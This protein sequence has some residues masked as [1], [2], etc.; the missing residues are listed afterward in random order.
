MA[1]NDFVKT[2]LT[3][4]KNVPQAEILRRISKASEKAPAVTKKFSVPPENAIQVPRLSLYDF[5][6]L[7]GMSYSRSPPSS[8]PFP[9][10]SNPKQT[11]R[12]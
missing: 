11:Y 4:L 6:V 10:V 9:V 1:L 12:R 3:W 2:Q 7:C 8:R 5:L